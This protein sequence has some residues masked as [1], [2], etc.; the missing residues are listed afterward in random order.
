MEK[1]EK[2]RKTCYICGF[3]IGGTPGVD[4]Q[5]VKTKRGEHYYCAKCVREIAKGG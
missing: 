5:Y 1:I 3:P 2:K 4:F